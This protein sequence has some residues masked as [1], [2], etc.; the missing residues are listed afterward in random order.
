MLRVKFLSSTSFSV[1]AN[2]RRNRE[3]AGEWNNVAISPYV[4]QR[5]ER[6]RNL[7]EYSVTISFVD[8]DS[9]LTP[10]FAEAAT[11]RLALSDECFG[12]SF[13]P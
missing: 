2:W 1:P 12:L 4:I 3:V 6:P 7:I 9:T 11:R 5:E 8:R 13:F 10:A